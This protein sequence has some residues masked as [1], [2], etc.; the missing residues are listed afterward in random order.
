MMA[1][2]IKNVTKR[3][4]G[5][6]ALDDVSVR[7]GENRIYGLLGNNGAGKTTLMNIIT[8]RLY[9]NAGE[10]IIDGESA[11]DND[12]ALG[13]IFMM[14]E[15]NMYPD[16]MRVKK[17]F[18]VSAMFY[19]DFDAAKALDLARR[20]GLD[21]RKK[22]TVLSTGYASIF[23]LVLALSV[24]TPYLLLDEP[25]LG[26]D[27][28][29]RDM[30]YRLLMEKYAEKPSTIIVSTHLIQEIQNLVEHAVIIKDG[31]IIKNAPT[32]ELL[33]EAYTVS[34]PAGLVDGYAASRNV[35][36]QNIFG[37]L[38]TA[39]MQGTAGA[40]PEGLELSKINLQDYFISLIG[41][42]EETK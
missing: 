36:S 12:R 5:V 1:I 7:F 2:E 15:Q 29:H 11:F 32:D 41:A 37:G 8:N 17:A 4:G 34:G 40:M 13:K 33:S 24:N 35:L 22:I 39:C 18:E 10:V 30:F 14:G 27:A 3:F 21:V 20:F 38:K 19:P 31:R 26:L 25:V 28:Q 23:R 9:P 16:G 6:Q 42:E